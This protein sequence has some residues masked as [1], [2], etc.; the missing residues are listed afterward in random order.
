MDIT[1]G[2]VAPQKTPADSSTEWIR[3]FKPYVLWSAMALAALAAGLMVPQLLSRPVENDARATP[4]ETKSPA[5]ESVAGAPESSD[6]GY[7]WMMTAAFLPAS[8]LIAMAWLWRAGA[9]TKR[10]KAAAPSL[11]VVETLRLG[12]RCLIYVIKAGGAELLAGVDRSGVRAVIPI[13]SVPAVS[14]SDAEV[15][16]REEPPPLK[17]L[18]ATDKAQEIDR[19]F[20]TRF[21]ELV[22]NRSEGSP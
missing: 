8:V 20:L 6:T 14:L 4:T 5:T 13:P 15:A 17:P 16:S 3:R 19:I 7:L 21:C 22:A 10:A 1:V 12:G 2:D 18:P 11:E 9:K